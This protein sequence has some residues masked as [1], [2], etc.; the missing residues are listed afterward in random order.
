MN[1]YNP[2]KFSLKV[3]LLDIFF[4]GKEYK[5]KKSEKSSPFPLIPVTM[6]IASTALILVTIFSVIHISELSS[7]I[8]SLKKQIVSLESK[9]ESL[10]NDIDHRFPYAQIIEE[11]EPLGFSKDAGTIIYI[12]PESN[13]DANSME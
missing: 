13:S 7:E 9:Q 11:V 4:G 5:T 10:Q 8:A 12:E 2:E 1:Q 3:F 6:F